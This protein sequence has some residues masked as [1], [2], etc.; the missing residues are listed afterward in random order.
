MISVQVT[1]DV[2]NA[3]EAQLKAE[4]GIELI[5]DVGEVSK[6]GVVVDFTFDRQEFTASIRHKPIFLTVGY[7]EGQLLGWLGVAKSS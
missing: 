7:C 6:E 2:F 1:R 5:G 4:Q 3:K